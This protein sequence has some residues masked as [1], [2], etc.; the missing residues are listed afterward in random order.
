MGA[1][2]LE[3][4]A[5]RDRIWAC[6]QSLLASLMSYDADVWQVRRWWQEKKAVVQAQLWAG[7]YQFRE[8][9][10]IQGKEGV[11]EMWAELDALGLELFNGWTE[12]LNNPI[13]S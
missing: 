2:I 10:R 7:T 6:F 1:R 12:R 3:C 4:C 8:L 9:R 11:T 5:L 13:P